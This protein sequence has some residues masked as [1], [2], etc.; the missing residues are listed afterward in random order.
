VQPICGRNDTHE[1][2]YHG[3]SVFETGIRDGEGLELIATCRRSV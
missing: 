2:D 1:A 3:F